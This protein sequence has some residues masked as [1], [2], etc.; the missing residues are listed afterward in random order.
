MFGSWRIRTKRIEDE[1]LAGGEVI[2][3]REVFRDDSRQLFDVEGSSLV[4]RVLA[5]QSNL[6]GGGNQDPCQHLDDRR[7]AGS[8]RTQEPIDAATLHGEID[9]MHSAYV[10]KVPSQFLGF[11]SKGHGAASV[12]L[13][14]VQVRCRNAIRVFRVELAS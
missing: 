11:D 9:R 12:G 14:V 2:E 4:P 1:V 8:V 10:A 5:K 3:Q 13:G 7:F 6:A